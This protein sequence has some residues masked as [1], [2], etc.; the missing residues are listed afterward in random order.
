MR[1][2]TLSLLMATNPMRTDAISHTSTATATKR[3][4]LASRIATVAVLATVSA[5]G[6]TGSA[7]AA[8][9]RTIVPVR[10]TPAKIEGQEIAILTDAPNVPPPITRTHATKV[11]V[12]LEVIE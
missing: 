12:N 1:K 5:T 10:A 9:N 6:C 2:P 11:I 7:D 8:E 4:A 3:V